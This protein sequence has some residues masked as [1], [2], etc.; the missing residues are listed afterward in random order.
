MCFYLKC[1]KSDVRLIFTEKQSVFD[2]SFYS[3]KY[4]LAVVIKFYKV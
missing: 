2:S 1:E 3:T 4:F